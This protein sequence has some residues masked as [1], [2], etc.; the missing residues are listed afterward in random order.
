[1]KKALLLLLA[2]S[3]L[4]ACC[5]CTKPAEPDAEPAAPEIT[6]PSAE[7]A[8]PLPDE[9]SVP[10]E[11]PAQ[12]DEPEIWDAPEPDE[13]PD[14][15]APLTLAAQR[16][17]YYGMYDEGM[18]CYVDYPRLRLTGS[19]AEAFPALSRALDTQNAAVYDEAYRTGTELTAPERDKTIRS[20][21]I[22]QYVTRADRQAL[23]LL[24][25]H[26][27]YDGGSTS[28]YRYSAVTLSPETGE[29][30]TLGDIVCDLAGLPALLEARLRE[31]YPDVSF[32]AL[33]Q[34]L[35]S[36]SVFEEDGDTASAPDYVWA[37]GY[38]S[39]EFYFDPGLIADETLGP[40]HVTLRFDAQDGLVQD[41]FLTRPRLYAELLAHQTQVSTDL[42][43]DGTA[44]TL[45]LDIPAALDGTWSVESLRVTVN[46]AEQTFPCPAN[47]AQ[48]QVC[49]LH[50]KDTVCL[51]AQCTDAAGINTLLVL[52]LDGSG[53]ALDGTYPGLGLHVRTED[54]A[55]WAELLTDPTQFLLDERVS[56]ESASLTAA[57]HAAADGTPEI[58]Q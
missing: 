13:G 58:G 4:L 32:H 55:Q 8:E 14:P 35:S 36:G 6:G 20:A 3:L 21:E 30:L 44:D 45:R 56:A 23:S 22:A 10:D 24:Y 51:Y 41:R 33:A 5:S 40:L 43:G 47:T 48:V 54:G 19:S 26:F 12:P 27:R 49:L 11:T 38:E 7:P 25:S 37:L 16:S 15:D 31:A 52:S 39:L 1:M 2:L 18:A 34:V 42:D 53:A 29:A 57:Y 17:R 28:D 46:G 9:P 50:L